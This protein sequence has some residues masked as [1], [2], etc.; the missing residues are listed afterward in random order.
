MQN[1]RFEDVY[2]L[3]S[4]EALRIAT[5][6]N[7]F[8]NNSFLQACYYDGEK[9]ESDL[10]NLIH[11]PI[12]NLLDGLITG[13]FRIPNLISFAGLELSD[14]VKEAVTQHFNEAIEHAKKYRIESN[15]QSFHDTR[16]NQPDF[17]E[18]LRFFIMAS[19]NTDVLQHVM[20][21]TAEAIKSMGYSVIYKLYYGIE[22][23]SYLKDKADYNPHVQIGINHLNNMC[24]NDSVVNI[25][26][27]QDPITM[28]FNDNE[29]YLRKRDFFFS[30]L[31]E[32]DILLDKKGISY[33]RQKF[34]VNKNEYKLDDTVIREKKIVFIGSS[35]ANHVGHDEKSSKTIQYLSQAFQDG[36]VFSDEKVEEISKLFSID[37]TELATYIIP[38]IIRDMSVILLCGIESDYEIEIYGM[39][40]EIY[41]SVRPYF[42]G[43]LAYGTDIS[44][45]YN[46]ATFALAPHQ[47]YILQQRVLEASAC[48]A[49][50]IVYDCRGLNDEDPYEEAFVYFRTLDDLKN[51]LQSS[52]APKKDFTR[53]HEENSYENFVNKVLRIVDKEISNG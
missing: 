50:P 6:K 42:K 36:V 16:N 40:W 31:S 51:I 41:D 17:S 8:D 32:F 47:N 39:G 11:L 53:L 28:F 45:I 21:A 7:R 30:L 12:E 37:K 52:N 2:F 33:A 48:G 15:L 9:I 38:Y 46:S 49:I 20:R 26:W 29:V 1:I 23:M 24:M 4:K 10:P 43:K 25:I 13:T 19:A 5:Q 27:I 44:K 18:P 3:N 22:D 35:Y 34:C 14:D